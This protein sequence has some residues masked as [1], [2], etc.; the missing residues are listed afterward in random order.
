MGK[1]DVSQHLVRVF[2]RGHARG[3]F[4]SA[5]NYT[6]PAIT[7]CKESLQQTVIVLCNLQ[8]LVALLEQE[9]NLKDTLSKKIQAAM[10]DKN[11]FLE[12]LD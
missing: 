6:V 11:P 9:R 7:T 12:I 4:I 8:E 2:G 3:I 1:G 10:I 5:S